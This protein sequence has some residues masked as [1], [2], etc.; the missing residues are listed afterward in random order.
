MTLVLLQSSSQP[1]IGPAAPPG[2]P[3]LARELLL[4]TG[5]IVSF[6]FLT[7][8]WMWTLAPAVSFKR[9]F[10]MTLIIAFSLG[11]MTELAQTYVP[12]RGAS[13]EDLLTNWFSTLGTLWYLRRKQ[14][15]RRTPA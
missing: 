14:G 9:R 3:S 15:Q 10:I 1:M 4:T 13:I 7:V 12:D 8:T 5:H 2:Q 6:A 11:L